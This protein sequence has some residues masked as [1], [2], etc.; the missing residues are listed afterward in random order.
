M[1]KRKPVFDGRSCFLPLL[2]IVASPVEARKIAH[3]PTVCMNLTFFFVDKTTIVGRDFSLINSQLRFESSSTSLEL[4]ELCE[5]LMLNFTLFL[6]LNFILQ[7]SSVVFSRISVER[8][9]KR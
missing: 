2:K 3:Q 8:M 6:K 7:F 5:Y 1:Q 9:G 4:R